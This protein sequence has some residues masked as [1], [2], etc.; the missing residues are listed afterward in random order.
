MQDVLRELGSTARVT[1]VTVA[2]DLS[3]LDEAR[4]AAQEAEAV[5]LMAGLVATEGV[6]QPNANM[7]N[8]QNRM[9]DELLGIN[10]TTYIVHVGNSADNTPHT[11]TLTVG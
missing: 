6:D 1:K 8:D 3:N 10:S 7:L 4:N 5:V 9:L 11:V 2:D